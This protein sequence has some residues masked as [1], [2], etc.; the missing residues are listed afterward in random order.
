MGWTVGAGVWVEVG[1]GSWVGVIEGLG[2]AVGDGVGVS[3][4]VGVGVEVL[5]G[6]G[7]GAELLVN[8]AILDSQILLYI[9]L[10]IPVK[11]PVVV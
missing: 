7:V 6:V 10:F 1:A 11:R 9:V 5:G 8:I 3:I 2:F 4:V